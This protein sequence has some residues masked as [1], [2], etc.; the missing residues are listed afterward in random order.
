M[1]N[2]YKIIYLGVIHLPRIN[3][4]CIAFII[5][6]IIHFTL[7]NFLCTIYQKKQ[8][9]QPFI[10][11]SITDFILK[12]LNQITRRHSEL[13]LL[14]WIKRSTRRTRLGLLLCVK[15][16]Y[17]LYWKLF[18][19]GFQPFS[20]QDNELTIDIFISKS[21]FQYTFIQMYI[22]MQMHLVV[23]VKSSLNYMIISEKSRLSQ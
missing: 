8:Q 10:V 23:M 20:P 6:K 14:L 9:E 5:V 16:T 18:L 21:K 12:L 17:I 2:I 13:C 11:V 22:P 15:V 4:C 1:I 19:F 3:A 7:C